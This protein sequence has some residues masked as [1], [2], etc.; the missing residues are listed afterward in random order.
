MFREFWKKQPFVQKIENYYS[1]LPEELRNGIEFIGNLIPTNAVEAFSAPT[2]L[3]KGVLRIL[4]DGTKIMDPKFRGSTAKT[5]KAFKGIDRYLQN[6]SEATIETNNIIRNM[7]KDG[8]DVPTKQQNEIFKDVA[9]K[10]EF[11][12]DKYR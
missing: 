5:R 7:W 1:Q 3:P 2:K 9:Q 12:Y 11:L 6:S 10:K 4:P 8:L